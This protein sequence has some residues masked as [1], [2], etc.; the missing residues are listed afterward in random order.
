MT[1]PNSNTSWT[2]T[3]TN[4]GTLAGNNFGNFAN[5]TGGT[6]D[7][8]FAFGNAGAL[9]GLL[10]GA[11]HSSGDT[12]NY[13]ALGAQTIDLGGNA[14]GVIRIENVVGNS[15]Q[16]LLGATNDQ[17]WTINGADDGTVVD[18]AT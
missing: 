16:T 6:A 3:G 11:S 2:I 5:L 15:N 1:G 12:A 4:S 13:S 18:Q 8:T 9:T 14:G 7:D 17:S 10:D